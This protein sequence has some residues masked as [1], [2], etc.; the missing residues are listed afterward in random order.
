MSSFLSSLTFLA[1]R[2]FFSQQIKI[3][4]LP[5]IPGPFFAFFM[6]SSKFKCDDI[7]LDPSF[8]AGLH[9]IFSLLYQVLF[10]PSMLDPTFF[11]CAI[12]PTKLRSLVSPLPSSL[13]HLRIDSFAYPPPFALLL[14]AESA[15]VCYSCSP[16]LFLFTLFCFPTSCG[17][18]RFPSFLLRLFNKFPL[19]GPPLLSPIPA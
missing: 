9:S 8:L 4:S 5:V 16:L 13:R 1:K 17:G 18:A 2:C 3:R 7:F 19:R 10:L 11:P 12:S 15:S 14:R 6:S